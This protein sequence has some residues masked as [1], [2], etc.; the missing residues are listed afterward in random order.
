MANKIENLFFDLDGRKYMWNWKYWMDKK[1]FIEPPLVITSKLNKK[2]TEAIFNKEIDFSKLHS[3]ELMSIASNCKDAGLYNVSHY[4]IESILSK[5]GEDAA[6]LSVLC[7]LLRKMGKPEEA[8]QRT[9]SCNSKN[10]PLLTSRA[11]AMC[12]LGLWEK[13]KKEISKAFALSGDSSNKGEAFS[14][15]SRIKSA[16]P[17][18]YE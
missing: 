11:A 15:Y 17:D 18:L 13:A 8:L 5:S 6:T 10:G 16:R 4:L 1:S 12:D 2:L 7:S 3:R 9:E 14:V